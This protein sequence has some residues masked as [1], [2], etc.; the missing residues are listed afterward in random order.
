M[1]KNRRKKVSA[2][3]YRKVQ[4]EASVWLSAL[5]SPVLSKEKEA[6]FFIWLEQDPLH[7][8]AYLEAEQLWQRGGVLQAAQPSSSSLASFWL[9][10]SGQFALRYS[11]AGGI[12]ASCLL[13]C[14]VFLTPFDFAFLDNERV[15]QYSTRVGEQRNVEL[16][17]GSTLMLNTN[18]RL[19]FTQTATQRVARLDFG[20]VFFD[21]EHIETAPFDVVVDA[22]RIRVHGT[23]FVVRSDKDQNL[24]TVKEGKVALMPRERSVVL[25][26][27]SGAVGEQSSPEIFLTAYQQLTLEEVALGVAPKQ[28]D[29]TSSMAWREGQLIARGEPLVD[30]LP[31]INRYFNSEIRIGDPSLSDKKVV[32]LIQLESLERTVALL[33]QSLAVRA[34]KNSK[35]GSFL[36]FPL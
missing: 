31:E 16:S 32:A 34:V 35:D 26:D 8:T 11:L 30:V 9:G 3:E 6:A 27:D 21:V 15:A 17:D 5:Q 12:V 2:R 24:V 29:V 14:F 23:Q 33:E 20:E 1:A 18:T 19:T 28:V 4:R 25:G 10:S 36:L 13:L 22:G 7:Q